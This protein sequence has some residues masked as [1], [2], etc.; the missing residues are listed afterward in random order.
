MAIWQP[1]VS[2][3]FIPW[4]LKQPAQAMQHLCGLVSPGIMLSLQTMTLSTS[5]N[6][7]GQ[8]PAFFYLVH[9]V[10]NG[11]LGLKCNPSWEVMFGRNG[12]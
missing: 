9:K 5:A 7:N 12:V 2:I 6:R 8:V 3:L 10:G 11:E 1:D 4:A